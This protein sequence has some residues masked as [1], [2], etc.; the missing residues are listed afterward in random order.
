MRAHRAWL[1]GPFI[2]NTK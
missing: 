1:F 2:D